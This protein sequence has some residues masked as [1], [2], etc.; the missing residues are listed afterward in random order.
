MYLLGRKLGYYPKDRDLGYL[1]DSLMDGL[2]DLQ[3]K[4]VG[5]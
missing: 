5:V 1:V 2:G 3:G 4:F